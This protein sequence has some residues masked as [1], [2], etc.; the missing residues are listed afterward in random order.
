MN[1]LRLEPSALT[2][3]GEFDSFVIAFIVEG[4]RSKHPRFV[5]GDARERP[6]KRNDEIRNL[7]LLGDT[8]G[9]Q[10]ED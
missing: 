4:R 8:D 1:S 2:Q 10:I 7:L 6:I 3:V 5:F 9:S